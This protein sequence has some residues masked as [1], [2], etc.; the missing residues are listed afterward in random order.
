MNIVNAGL[1]TVATGLV[2]LGAT[3]IAGDFYVGAGEIVL[4]LLVYLAYELTPVKQ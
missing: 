4:G 3:T 1:Q 2:A